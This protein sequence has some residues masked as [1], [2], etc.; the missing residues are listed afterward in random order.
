M[1]NLFFIMWLFTVFTV[2]VKWATNHCLSGQWHRYC[3]DQTLGISTC[4][5]FYD[6]ARF[7]SIF[8]LSQ[9]ELTR[10]VSKLPEFPGNCSSSS[11]L[12]RVFSHY[13]ISALVRFRCESDPNNPQVPIRFPVRQQHAFP[14]LSSWNKKNTLLPIDAWNSIMI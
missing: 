10:I 14:D 4:K 5:Q 8:S 3:N 11:E 7:P 1:H 9:S 13:P 2:L 6:P 12:T